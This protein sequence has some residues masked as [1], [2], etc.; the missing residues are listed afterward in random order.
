MEPETHA[1]QEQAARI[2][3]KMSNIYGEER[4]QLVDFIEQNKTDL[5]TV[6][7]HIDNIKKGRNE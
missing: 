2:V 3:E 7:V 1:E 5:N 4:K 6:E